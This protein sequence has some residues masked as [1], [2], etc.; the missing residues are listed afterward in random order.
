MRNSIWFPDVILEGES[1][2]IWALLHE[3]R[4]NCELEPSSCELQEEQIFSRM[5]FLFYTF[6]EGS[7]SIKVNS[8]SA[9]SHY[10]C[11]FLFVT[12]FTVVYYKCHLFDI[13]VAG[14]LLAFLGKLM[15]CDY[16]RRVH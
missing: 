10:E 12:V 8:S 9:I 14:L 15:L 5:D 1:S 16:F 7:T 13:V 4:E 3:K 2:G 11:I 6:S